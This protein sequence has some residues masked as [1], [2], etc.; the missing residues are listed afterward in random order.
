M[1]FTGDHLEILHGIVG[2]LR[3]AG[4]IHRMRAHR[5]HADGVAVR[6]RLGDGFRTDGTAA[7]ATILDNQWLTDDAAHLIGNQP[8]HDICR[9]TRRKRNDVANRFVRV[10]LRQCHRT[11][12]QHQHGSKHSQ[13]SGTPLS[14]FCRHLSIH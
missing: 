4:R 6:R 13:S 3:I 5:R 11:S 1:S 7:T 9:A 10:T 8:P 12:R 14:R 2:Q